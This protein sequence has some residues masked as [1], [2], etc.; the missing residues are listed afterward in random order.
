MNVSH[1]CRYYGLLDSN[2]SQ[3]SANAKTNTVAKEEQSIIEAENAERITLLRGDL[4]AGIY[5]LQ[6][7]KDG[8]ALCYLGEIDTLK[9]EITEIDQNC[10]DIESLVVVYKK[11][12]KNIKH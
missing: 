8:A 11:K 7:Q 12:I 6:V 10:E 1:K 5:K 4:V 9:D 2:F 3:A